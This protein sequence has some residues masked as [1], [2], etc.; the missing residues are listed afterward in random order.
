M[1]AQQINKSRMFYAATQ[2]LDDNQPRFAHMAELAA[3][4]HELKGMVFR[5]DEHRQVQVV[6]NTGL[7]RN[8][9]T[10]REEL[11]N[12]LLRISAGLTA[13]AAA[14]GDQ[15]LR[16]KAEYS[17]SDLKKSSDRILCD[18]AVL[19]NSLAA[20]SAE[21]LRT[22]FVGPDELAQFD[23]LTN[24]FKSILPLRRAAASV[25][26]VSTS[27]ISEVFHAIDAL[28]KNKIDLLMQ[29]FRFTQPDFFKAYKNARV[30]VNYTG[31]GKAAATAAVS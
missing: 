10:L 27:N 22:Y 15:V 7:T 30:I 1:N 29:P 17:L 6:D 8:K 19:I 23:R 16:A 18:I 12:L 2:V 28:L 14:T 26:K 31:R 21:A 13:H 11:T 5:I 20:N 4:H 25:S 24:A 3:A 9:E